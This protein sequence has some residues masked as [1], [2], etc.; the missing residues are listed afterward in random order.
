MVDSR[1]GFREREGVELKRFPTE[2]DLFRAVVSSPEF[3]ELLRS[4]NSVTHLLIEPKGLFGVPDILLANVKRSASDIPRVRAIAF[5]LKLRDWRR[6]LRQAYRYRAF[7]NQSYVIL[8]A[9][10]ARPAIRNTEL[11]V[12]FNVGL[13]CIDLEGFI[14]IHHEPV[15]D[16]PFSTRQKL[17][18]HIGL[19]DILSAAREQV[20]GPFTCV[21]QDFRFRALARKAA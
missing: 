5:E 8:D 9:S 10:N 18:L 17:N 11:F 13:V 14:T 16:R 21:L 1:E 15:Y 3:R 6:G 19:L 12:R 2:N 7:A 4:E 20:E